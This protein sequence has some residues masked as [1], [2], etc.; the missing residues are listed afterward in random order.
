MPVFYAK[1]PIEG[2]KKIYE[3][4]IANPVFQPTFSDMYE[5]KYRKDGKP[6]K[7]TKK[8]P[9]PTADEV[10]NSKLKPSWL[11]VKDRGAYAMANTEERLPGEESVNFCVYCEGCDPDVN[12]DYYDRQQA[13]FGGDD[14]GQALPLEWLKMAIDNAEACGIDIM[15]IKVTEEGFELVRTMSGR[16]R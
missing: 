14:F 9:W 5:A 8:R 15:I 16:G 1:F 4:S 12:E 3:H 10:D 2:I 11:L 13:V 7:E 6:F